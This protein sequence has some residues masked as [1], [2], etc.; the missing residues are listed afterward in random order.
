MD[1]VEVVSALQTMPMRSYDDLAPRSP[2]APPKV[3]GFYAWWQTPDALPG[4]PGTPHPTAPVELLYVGIGPGYPASKSNLRRRLA[5]HHRAEI[6]RSTFRLDLTAFLWEA[7]GWQCRWT[8][9]VKL[10]RPGLD[11][12][13]AWQRQHL[14]V[15]WVEV[16]APWRL[17]PEVVQLMRPPL[18]RDHNETHPFYA[19]VGKAR[20]VLRAAARA[21]SA[22]GF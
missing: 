16:T 18:N 2:T 3:S 19:A 6:G 11:E 7:R 4:V 22:A 10:D 12:L 17:E 20:E 1:A 14:S 5:S 15:Q 8:D 21:R 9:R 13:A